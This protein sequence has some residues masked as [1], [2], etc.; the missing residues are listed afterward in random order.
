M[1]K[2]EIIEE[3]LRCLRLHTIAEKLPEAIQ[4]EKDKNKGVER[5]PD[6]KLSE[7]DRTK[8]IDK[9]FEGVLPPT[10]TPIVAFTGGPTGAGK[11]SLLNPFKEQ[12]PDLIIIDLNKAHL[13]P[14]HDIINTLVYCA[15][16]S[17]VESVVINGKVVMLE[18]TIQTVNENNIFW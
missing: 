18:R 5:A 12:H 9:I 8:L 16:A 1:S 15:R 7:E 13:G 14:T 11:G 4:Q 10:G 3:K 2:M 17:D 6:I